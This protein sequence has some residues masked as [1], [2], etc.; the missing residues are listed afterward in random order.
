MP[1]MVFDRQHCR[2]R[3]WHGSRAAWLKL[4]HAVA[5]GLCVLGTAALRASA[6]LPPRPPA[7]R[8]APAAVG[9]SGP[10]AAVFL[11][12]PWLSGALRTP[13]TPPPG[14]PLL[15][16]GGGG[17]GP[18]LPAPG[19]LPPPIVTV[20]TALPP[21]SPPAPVPEPGTTP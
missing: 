11:P 17:G 2:W 7:P 19:P 20:T 16:G 4:P 18:P 3:P 1:M 14:Q 21:V 12:T 9:R 13:G 15:P 10:P 6:P 8:P 5:T